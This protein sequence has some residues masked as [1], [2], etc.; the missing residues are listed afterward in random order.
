[1]NWRKED[2]HRGN[3]ILVNPSYPIFSD[4]VLSDPSS[5]CKAARE[6]GALSLEAPRLDQ[7]QHLMQKEAAGAL[8]ALLQA[9][10]EAA[11]KEGM[12]KEGTTKEGEAKEGAAKEG[13]AKEGMAR[14]ALVSGF[15]TMEEQQKIWDDSLAENGPEYTRTFVAIPGHS[16]HQTGLA[17]DVALDQPGI[18]FICPQFPDEGVCGSFRRLAPCYGFIERYPAGKEAVTHIGA[19]PWHF[20]YVGTPH[21]ALM[22]RL[23][24]VL[25]EYLA[26]LRQFRWE[27][28]PYCLQ[29]GGES[30]RIGWMPFQ[31]TEPGPGLDFSLMKEGKIK[32][33]G[34]NIDGFI[35][36][37][38]CGRQTL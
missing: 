26:W 20:R 7:P 36:T 35:I 34:D 17:M 32:I 10:G 24:M 3:L 12:T 37:Q 13:A 4:P 33:S 28:R 6:R 23:H 1:M 19:E 8:K 5:F 14:I 27:Y 2:I 18:D 29:E 15:R 21:A 38:R 30:F 11:L 31:E 22:Q 9:A 25:E 16:E